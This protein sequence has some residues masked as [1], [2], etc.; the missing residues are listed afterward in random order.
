MFQKKMQVDIF[1]NVD[2]LQDTPTDK[3]IC[4]GHLFDETKDIS[5]DALIPFFERDLFLALKYKELPE[6]KIKF[7]VLNVNG[8]DHIDIIIEDHIY[9]ELGQFIIGK[10]AQLL[11][12]YNF[13]SYHGKVDEHKRR[14][15]Y[16]IRPSQKLF[17]E[18]GITWKK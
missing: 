13:N 10:L 17:N 15:T 11:W 12:K 7:D 3:M 6:L 1:K 2:R 4:K 5:V 9:N 14:F 16:H 8:Q 18:E